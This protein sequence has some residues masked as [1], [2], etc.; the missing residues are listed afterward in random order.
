LSRRRRG[1][2]ETRALIR[3]LSPEAAAAA[4]R[5]RVLLASGAIGLVVAVLV[6][7][8]IANTAGV[9]ESGEP[10]A[11][12]SA[13]GEADVIEKVTSVP[14]DV[15]D[16]V[17][18][19]RASRAPLRIQAPLLTR[20][21]KPRVLYVGAEFCPFCAAE[22]WP[23]VVAMSRFGTWSGLT[24][25]SSASD[26]VFPDTPTLSFSGATYRS[27]YLSF[28]GVETRGRDKVDGEYEPLQPLS[29]ADQRLFDTFNR[30]PYTAGAPGA[31]P[32]VAYGGEYAGSGASY[33]PELLAGMTHEE[34]AD[35][36]DD[37]TDM[38]A[39]AIDGSANVLTAALCELTGNEP[40]DVCTSVGVV[41]AARALA[42]AQQ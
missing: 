5:R 10:P 4:R 14:P 1:D 9:G 7:L 24:T 3:A 23:L 2:A 26:D 27:D 21:G 18:V 17:G 29:L 28:T 15:L 35:A 42:E 22:R 32:F 30:P 11:P 39:Q 40:A 8:V 38:V 25:T 19:G 41:T 20:D 31:I 36:L 37:P 16:E 12:P 6:G 13:G 34:V 33:S